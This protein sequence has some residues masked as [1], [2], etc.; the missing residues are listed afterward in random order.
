MHY[1]RALSLTAASV[2]VGA[3]S[4]GSSGADASA[5]AAV[6]ASTEADDAQEQGPADS[7]L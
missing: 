3:L 2:L 6:P 5:A 1:P 7:E 4:L